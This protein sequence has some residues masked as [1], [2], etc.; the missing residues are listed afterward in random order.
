MN[1][2]SQP[3]VS[4]RGDMTVWSDMCIWQLCGKTQLQ[5]VEQWYKHNLEQV[6]ENTGF[7][8]LCTFSVQCDSMVEARRLDIASSSLISK[9][10]R[11]R[12]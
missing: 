11:L 3:N 10:R 12:S 5:Q 4:N 1:A 9:Q 2:A 6:V 8:V 7:K